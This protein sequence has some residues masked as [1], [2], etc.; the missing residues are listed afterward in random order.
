MCCSVLQSVC[1]SVLQCVAVCCS[2]LQCSAVCYAYLKYLYLGDSQ[3]K[4]G[5]RCSVLQYVAVCLSALQCAATCYTY[6]TYLNVYIC[7]VFSYSHVYVHIEYFHTEHAYIYTCSQIV[8][9]LAD[10]LDT[11]NVYIFLYCTHFVFK[12]KKILHILQ[13]SHVIC[14]HLMC[15]CCVYVAHIS[16]DIAHIS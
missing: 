12:K 15:I 4:H 6:L 7:R 3:W 2:V 14:T 1:C 10:L 13:T 8:D 11:S 5:C 16:C 9:I